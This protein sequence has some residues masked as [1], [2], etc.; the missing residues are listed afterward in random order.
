[1]VFTVKPGLMSSLEGSLHGKIDEVTVHARLD[2]DTTNDFP[3]CNTQLI[4][5]KEEVTKTEPSSFGFWT[6]RFS[7]NR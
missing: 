2:A 6:I 4:L 1:M 3:F 5:Q 7:E